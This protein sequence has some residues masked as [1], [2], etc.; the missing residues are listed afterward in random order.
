M[1]GGGGGGG[2][3]ENVYEAYFVVF[4]YIAYGIFKGISVNENVN[5][6][7]YRQTLYRTN[8]KVQSLWYRVLL[9]K[10]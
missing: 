1:R 4:I 7:V 8:G 3:A 6:L 10:N 5:T 2:G 9:S